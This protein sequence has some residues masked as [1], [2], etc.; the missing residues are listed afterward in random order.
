MKSTYTKVA[1]LHNKIPPNA[2]K[3]EL[4]VLVEVE[5]IA[6]ALTELGHE[7]FIVPFSLDLNESIDMLMAIKP[8]FVFN[9]VESVQNDGQLIHL[10]PSILDH[11]RIPYTGCPKDA[12]YITSNKL[13]AKRFMKAYEIPTP[14]WMTPEEIEIRKFNLADSY[15]V[16]SVWE[17][18]SIGLDQNSVVSFKNPQHIRDILKKRKI[19]NGKDFFAEKYVE[20]REFNISILAGKVL[21]IPEIKFL[22]FP[23]NKVKVVDYRAKWDEDSFEYQHTVRSFKHDNN[24]ESLMEELSYITKRVWNTFGLKG[25]ARVDFRV[26]TDGNPYVIDINANP[27]ISPD[28]GFVAASAQIG[29]KYPQI[30]EK[31]VEDSIKDTSKNVPHLS[32]YFYKFNQNHPTIAYRSAVNM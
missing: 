15:I 4:D 27:C 14:E 18:A 9:L 28:A 11:L 25:Y 2:P 26:S 8:D 30:V 31:I 24:D 21:P 1:V 29:L 32:D 17:H 3:D 6:N 7:T 20:G 23:S 5:A 12:I 22:N 13:L 16:K 10:A 19:A